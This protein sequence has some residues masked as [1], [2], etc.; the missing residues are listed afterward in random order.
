LSLLRDYPWREALVLG[1]AGA[2]AIFANAP[3]GFALMRQAPHPEPIPTLD[4]AFV[5]SFVATRGVVIVVFTALGLLLARRVG[6]GAPYIERWLY[7]TPAARPFATILAPALLLGA[8]TVLVDIALD[9][10][11]FLRGLGLTAPAPEIHSRLPRIAAW[12][13]LLTMFGG[14]ITEELIF[15]LFLLSLFAWLFALPF[16]ARRVRPVRAVLWAA[17]LASALLF[18]LAHMEGVG[19]FAT[20]TTLLLARTVVFIV[21]PGLAFGWLFWTYGLEAAMLAHAAADV[22]VHGIR[23]LFQG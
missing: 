19:L 13:G 3:Y 6:L 8:G 7:G 4:L 16:G 18:G 22:V 5:V 10:T 23:P 2:V 17:N 12:K 20:V 11:L 21:L 1:A 9:E 14:G 15:R